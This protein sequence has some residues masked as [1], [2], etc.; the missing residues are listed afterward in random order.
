MDDIDPRPEEISEESRRYAEDFAR[1][2]PFGDQD[3]NG[4]DLSLLRRNLLLTP[5]QRIEK[6]TKALSFVLEIERDR[7]A[8][9]S[10]S[11][12]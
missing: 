6:M 2:H 1:A 9:L 10:E 3:E 5:T 7:R 4:I 11:S 12:R 8:R